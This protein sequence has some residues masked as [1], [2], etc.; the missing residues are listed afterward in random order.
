MKH[1]FEAS[2]I[3]HRFIKT[4]M[5][6]FDENI[7]VPVSDKLSIS[8]DDDFTRKGDKLLLNEGRLL[9]LPEIIRAYYYRAYYEIRFDEKLRSIII[10]SV[11]ELEETQEY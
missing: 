1:Y 11:H 6:R 2:T 7:S 8:I 5:K 3:I 4:L 10:E 9:G